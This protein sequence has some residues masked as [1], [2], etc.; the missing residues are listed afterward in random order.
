MLALHHPPH[1]PRTLGVHLL[2][3]PMR[4]GFLTSLLKRRS[5][6][7]P[8]KQLCPPVA[9]VSPCFLSD[10]AMRTLQRKEF[11]M[12][13]RAEKREATR[14][15]SFRLPGAT[16]RDLAAVARARGVDV[17][18][19]LNWLIAE[20]RPALMKELAEHEA[21]LMKAAA[22][23][24]W[25]KKEPAEALRELRELLGKLQDEYSELSKQVLGK[26]ERRAG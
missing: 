20:A 18:G 1:C 10:V 13:K 9:F 7:R 12:P 25:A 24:E 5:G 3:G 6:F 26:G 17:S 21:A 14:S 15:F 19:V 23:R 2:V 16:F 22:S 11:A 8:T 4:P